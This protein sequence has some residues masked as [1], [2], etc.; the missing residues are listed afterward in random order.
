MLNDIANC[1]E[2]IE[3]RINLTIHTL[4]SYKDHTYYENYCSIRTKP[5]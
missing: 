2:K 5:E 1:K 3:K 4:Q